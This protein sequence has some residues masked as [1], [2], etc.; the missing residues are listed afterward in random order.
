M[1]FNLPNCSFLY[2]SLQLNFVF[3]AGFFCNLRLKYVNQTIF[4]MKKCISVFTLLLVI[5]I[6][7][8]NSGGES[9]EE[10][11]YEYE[12]PST[13]LNAELKA[14]IGDWAENGVEC[15]G[16][17][18]AIDGNG[19]PQYG[20]PIKAKIVQIKASKIKMKA[21]ESINM[22]PKEG[23]SKMGMSYGESWWETDGELYQTKE[24]AEAYLRKQGLLKE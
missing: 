18:V 15:Y 7:G 22:G 2:D 17:L 3:A 24:E 14:K 10:A 21:L 13:E 4:Y 8:C 5:A 1:T 19:F 9:N 23:C 16:V 12:G 20:M 11:S 6:S